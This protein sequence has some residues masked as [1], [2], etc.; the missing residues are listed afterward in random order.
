MGSFDCLRRFWDRVH[1]R[2]FADR[3][4]RIKL[5]P[6]VEER[7]AVQYLD[8]SMHGLTLNW[9]EVQTQE[10]MP[11]FTNEFEMSELVRA[12]AQFKVFIPSSSEGVHTC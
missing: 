11:F 5:C 3:R 1:W 6:V 7:S 4:K 8:R 2:V 12:D 9:I 10:T